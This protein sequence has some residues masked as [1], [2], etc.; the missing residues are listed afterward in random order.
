MGQEGFIKRMEKMDHDMGK[1]KQDVMWPKKGKKNNDFQKR[2]NK[3][4][5]DNEDSYK[6]RVVD[7]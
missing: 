4:E 7:S 5:H 2:M 3:L 6:F 1:L